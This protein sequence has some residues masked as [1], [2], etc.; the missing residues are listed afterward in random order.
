M[1]LR[2]Q[3]AALASRRSSLLR[4]QLDGHGDAPLADILHSLAAVGVEPLQ[5][6][7]ALWTA[8]EHQA[9]R[10]YGAHTARAAVGE[11]QA[12]PVVPT[13]NHFG[14][15]TFADSVQGTLLYSL[16]PAP[17]GEPRRTV[18]VFGFGSV[19]LNNLT[20]PMGIRLYDLGRGDIARLPQRLP[21]L[22]KR[23]RDRFTSGADSFDRQMVDRARAR[24]S[25]LHRRGDVTDFGARA[26]EDI[27][28]NDFASS[29]ALSLP[30]YGHQGTWIN[31][32]LWQ[33]MLQRVSFPP[34]LVQLHIESICAAVLATDLLDRTSLAHQ[35]LFTPALRREVVARLDG[36]RACW[37]RARL[38]ERMRRAVP[39]QRGGGTL[40]F[41]GVS[42]AKRLVPLL[43][44]ETGSSPRLRGVDENQVPFECEFTPDALLR[45][46]DEGSLMPSLFTCFTALGFGRALACVGGFYQVTYLPAMQRAIIAA[47][48]SMARTRAAASLLAR[49][50]TTR[51]LAGLQ[52]I[53]RVLADGAVIP[54]GPIE[55]AGAGGLDDAD[56]AR[57][58]S[59][60]VRDA[61]LMGFTESLPHLLPDAELPRDWIR[62]L[63]REN[64]T[65][66]DQMLRLDCST[67]SNRAMAAEVSAQLG[68]G[69]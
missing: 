45:A 24:L 43:L 46:L 31:A 32:R 40:F 66:C 16:R 3:L 22:P 14:V 47:L 9:T 59:V 18:V 10:Y 12:D 39:V 53:V 21:I 4:D 37:N 26:A 23:D 65:A 34:Q 56:L 68:A 60:S 38:V 58:R 52:P 35:L 20:Y 30:T 63:A 27:L 67:A 42:G 44:D 33:R 2:D 11:L 50:P 28:A 13:S 36:V 25:A 8:I 57:L 69:R 48:R 64:S 1:Y 7:D 29:E 6:R 41:W 54:A 19:S 62:R 15:D 5:A 61:C 49:V 51:Y 55:I 17:N